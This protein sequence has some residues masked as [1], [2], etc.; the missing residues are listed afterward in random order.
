MAFLTFAK[1]A[2]IDGVSFDMMLGA[3][4]YYTVVV[5]VEGDSR[6]DLP[7]RAEGVDEDNLLDPLGRA[8]RV[9]E[10]KTVVE[11]SQVM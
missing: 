4:Y 9:E 6:L 2:Q 8:E 5:E 11:Q 7:G 3:R 10:D 1:V